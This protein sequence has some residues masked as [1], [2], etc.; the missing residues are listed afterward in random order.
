[1]TLVFNKLYTSTLFEEYAFINNL[2]T[3]LLQ[4]IIIQFDLNNKNIELI[5]T[6]TSLSPS[7][8]LSSS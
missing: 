7:V 8:R 5:N 3:L 6:P 4:Y 1:M 2:D